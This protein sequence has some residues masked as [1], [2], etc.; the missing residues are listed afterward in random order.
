MLEAAWVATLAE[1]PRLQTERRSI[2]PHHPYAILFSRYW[3]EAEFADLGLARQFSEMVAGAVDRGAALEIT[4]TTIAAG[5]SP[6]MACVTRH[7]T[8]VIRNERYQ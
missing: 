5:I 2:T 8:S 7:L 4:A 1:L 3:P 6:K